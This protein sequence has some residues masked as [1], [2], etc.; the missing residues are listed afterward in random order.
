[1][2]T[3]TLIKWQNYVRRFKLGED[4]LMDCIV[5]KLTTGADIKAIHIWNK[6][7][8]KFRQEMG[9]QKKSLNWSDTQTEHTDLSRDLINKWALLSPRFSGAK[10]ETLLIFLQVGD[11][12]KVAKLQG[13]PAFTVKSRLN[14]FKIECAELDLN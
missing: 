11:I 5:N 4:S 14:A 8:N 7:R 6:A 2:D 12:K 1:M 9:E 3:L 10:L 13:L